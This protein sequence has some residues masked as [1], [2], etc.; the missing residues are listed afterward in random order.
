MRVEG[1]ASRHSK[2]IQNPAPKN[3]STLRS[4]DPLIADENHVDRH[5]FFVK[6]KKKIENK[7]QD[8]TLK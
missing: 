4:K 2:M 7:I 1:V 8:P 5:R 3:R 6:A